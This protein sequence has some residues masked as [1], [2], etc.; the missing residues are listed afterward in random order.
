MSPSSTGRPSRREIG[1]WREVLEVRAVLEPQREPGVDLAVSGVEA[2]E[3]QPA[4]GE[5]EQLGHVLGGQAEVR[6][7][8]AVD[9]DLDLL[10]ALGAR[11]R[12]VLDAVHGLEPPRRLV[13]EVVQHGGVL[14][15]QLDR[16]VGRAAALV[17]LVVEHDPD[18]GDLRQCVPDL[19]SAARLTSSSS[20]SLRD[21]M[22]VVPARFSAK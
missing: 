19:G 21:R 9:G 6:G 20:R 15:E 22:M 11:P 13:G 14:P 1:I 2:V 5:G 16:E 18:S 10:A 12:H 3:A 7:L 8:V 4:E 17:G